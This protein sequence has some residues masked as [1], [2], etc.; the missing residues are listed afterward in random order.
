MQMAHDALELAGSLGVLGKHVFFN[1]NWVA[2]EDRANYFLDADVGV[3]T[4]LEHL[5]TSF[6]FR[7]RLL[8]YIWA[9]LPIINSS[10]DAFESVITE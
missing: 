10:G 8:D 9:G 4:H 2:H 6:S 1:E 7:T 3:S 5:E